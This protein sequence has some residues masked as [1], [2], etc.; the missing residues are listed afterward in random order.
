MCNVSRCALTS[1]SSCDLD[2]A[3]CSLAC[4]GTGW[5]DGQTCVSTFDTVRRHANQTWGVNYQAGHV[6]N[7]LQGYCNAEG[8]CL[9]VGSDLDAKW[10]NRGGKYFAS[11]WW[12]A[13]L[14]IIGLILLQFVVRRIHR[15][16][17][18]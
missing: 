13:I 9:Q 1:A 12:G 17:R 2:S 8:D 18:T 3:P 4:R 5:G 15:I 14:A 7:A 10:A 6:C 16:K 11:Y